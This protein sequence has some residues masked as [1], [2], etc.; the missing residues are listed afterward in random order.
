VQIEKS[1]VDDVK[2]MDDMYDDVFCHVV[3]RII[4][5]V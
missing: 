1:S 3:L 5:A 4:A 2:K